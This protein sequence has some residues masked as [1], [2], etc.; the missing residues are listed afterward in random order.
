MLHIRNIQVRFGDIEAVAGVDLD[1]AAGEVVALMGPSGCGKSTL[2]RVISGLTVP[3]AGTVEWEGNDITTTPPHER[4]IGLMFQDYALF[5]HLDVRGNVGFG[6]RMVG[7]SRDKIDARVR[8][9]LDLVGLAGYE[10]RPIAELSGGEQQRVA[11]ARTIASEP[12]L[13][14]LDEPIG[15]LDRTLRDRLMVDMSDLF[16]NLAISVLY[17]THDQHEAFAVANRIAVMRA[18]RIVQVASPEELWRKPKSGFVARFMGLDNV[19]SGRLETGRLDLGWATLPLPEV[20][21]GEVEIV[22]PPGAVRVDPAGSIDAR[23]V[24]ATYRGEVYE[25]RARCRDA[26][27][28]FASRS[29]VHPGEPIRVSIDAERIIPLAG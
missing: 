7:H 12:K 2:L 16:A 17:V 22:I 24:S 18:G 20:G 10:E 15:A 25:I 23:V 29:H 13:V 6:P 9:V 4:G 11:L 8:D 19:F 14:M 1:V 5:P 27:I 21:D 26:T 28:H 3:D